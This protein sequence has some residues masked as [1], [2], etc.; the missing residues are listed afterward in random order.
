MKLLLTGDLHLGRTSTRLPSSQR[1]RA[2]TVAGWKRIVDA[3]LEE[4]VTAVIL[5]GDVLDEANRY[6]ESLTPFSEGIARLAA[7]GIRTIA[8]SGNHDADVLPSLTAGFPDKEV[9]LLGTQGWERVTLKDNGSPVVHIDGWSFPTKTVRTDP[10]RD[11]TAPASDGIPV[12]GVVHGDLGAT[13]STYAPLS[14]SQLQSLPVDGWLLGHLHTHSFTPGSPWVLMPGSPHPLDPGEP[15][16]HHAWIVTVDGGHLSSP[17]PVCPADLI[18]QTV[19]IELT[20]EAPVNPDALQKRI[21]TSLAPTDAFQILRI[22]FTGQ[23][24]DPEELAEVTAS[25]T[26]WEDSRFCIEKV[27]L[28]LE[29]SLHLDTLEEAGPVPSRIVQALKTLPPEL[30]DRLAEVEAQLSRQ[31]EFTSHGLKEFSG[32]TLP[33]QALLERTLR[34]ALEEESQ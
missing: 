7:Q 12:L 31:K 9:L 10:T 3:A 28:D 13:D 24:D 33:V 22:R 27:L 29:S 4:Q 15:E 30:A 25:L 6:W 16:I 32:E 14:L 23:T 18:Y 2:R 21:L 34:A 8:V 1:E 19:D 5:S 17:E 11:Y 26:D 20:A